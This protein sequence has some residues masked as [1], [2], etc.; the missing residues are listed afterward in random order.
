MSQ[1]EKLFTHWIPENFN[2]PLSVIRFF[3]GNVRQREREFPKT[4][5]KNKFQYSQ[6]KNVMLS[7]DR[8]TTRIE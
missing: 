6:T 7:C 4:Q 1:R 8:T 5:I 3:V 2:F